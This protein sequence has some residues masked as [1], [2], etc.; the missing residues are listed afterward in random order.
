MNF[1]STSGLLPVHLRFTI[2]QFP[3]DQTIGR[4]SLREEVKYPKCPSD[5]DMPL[6]IIR[7]D[8]T[9][10]IIWRLFCKREHIFTKNLKKGKKMF[11]K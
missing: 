4:G 11:L 7:I 8:M 6:N 2:I 3:V 10:V 9:H 1:L 5:D